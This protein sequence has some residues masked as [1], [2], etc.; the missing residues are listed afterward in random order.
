MVVTA[1][2]QSKRHNNEIPEGMPCH[3]GKCI[4]T[5][6]V[7]IICI[8]IGVFLLYSVGVVDVFS[9]AAVPLRS[10]TFINIVNFA[11]LKLM[12]LN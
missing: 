12:A 1:I 5:S 11:A 7:I 10:S 9:A 2:D 3:C 6:T 8:S 4:K